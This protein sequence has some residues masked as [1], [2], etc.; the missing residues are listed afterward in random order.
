MARRGPFMQEPRWALP[1]LEHPITI[2]AIIIHAAIIIRIRAVT[3]RIQSKASF[4]I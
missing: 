4:G 2:Q 3:N 1:L